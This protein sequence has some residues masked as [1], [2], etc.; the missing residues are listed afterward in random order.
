MGLQ[1]PS[2]EQNDTGFCVP[3]TRNQS[4]F[5]LQYFIEVLHG[6]NHSEVFVNNNNIPIKLQSWILQV[7]LHVQ[8]TSESKKKEHVSLFF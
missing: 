4:V 2:C 7:P 3:N 5:T 6:K 8:Q 1:Q